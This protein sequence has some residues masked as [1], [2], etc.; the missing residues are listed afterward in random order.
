LTRSK[1]S[2]FLNPGVSEL[3]PL[4]LFDL[5]AMMHRGFR[6]RVHWPI[7]SAGVYTSSSTS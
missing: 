4:I 7:V 2:C 1:I 5:Q 6:N 3:R